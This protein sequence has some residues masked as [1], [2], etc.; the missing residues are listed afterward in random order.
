MT[1]ETETK[2][3]PEGTDAP[4]AET[5]PADAETKPPEPGEIQNP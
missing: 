4:P 1:T 5:K 3:A 2:P